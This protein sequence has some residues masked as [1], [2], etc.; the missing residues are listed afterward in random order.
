MN[1]SP[2]RRR[3][4]PALGLLAAAFALSMSS[5]PAARADTAVF[6]Q[7]APAPIVGGPYAGAD[8]AMLVINGVGNQDQNFGARANFEVGEFPLQSNAL[9][10]TL[11]RFDVTALAGQY[12]SVDAVTLRLFP[13]SVDTLAPDSVNAFRV[14]PANAAW[15]E[16]TGVGVTGSDPPDTGES[17]WAQRVQGSQNWA[18]S[19]GASTAGTDYAVTAI[20]STPFSAA[21]GTGVANPFDIVL[22]PAQLAATFADWTAG[23]NSGLF[24]RVS[25]ESDRSITFHSAEAADPAVR[26]ELIVTYT[27]VPEPCGVVALAAVAGVLRR[28]RRRR[29]KRA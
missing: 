23:N 7:G 22:T 21:T 16:G 9:R 29:R 1:G 4:L 14:A 6:K 18:G 20:G 19:A 8:D 11:M 25:A 27:P 2:R 12:A 10:H 24:L 26:P 3:T 13:I 28:D 5:A 17:T 15:V